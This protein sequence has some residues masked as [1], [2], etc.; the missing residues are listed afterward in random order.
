MNARGSIAMCVFVGC[1]ADFED[2]EGQHSIEK[3]LGR[4]HASM[5]GP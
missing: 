1:R 3:G 2:F 4:A 5:D